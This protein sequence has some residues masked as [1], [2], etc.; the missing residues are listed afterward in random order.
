MREGDSF[1]SF[2]VKI[3][4]SSEVLYEWQK[5]HPE[6]LQAKRMAMDACEVWWECQGKQGLWDVA[7]GRGEGSVILNSSKWIFN[8]KARFGWRDKEPDVVN[9]VNVSSQQPASQESLDELQAIF[10]DLNRSKSK[11]KKEKT[12][13]GL[14]KAK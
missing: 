9:Q 14:L 4:V 13:K 7:G 6:F 12:T 5:V 10:Q 3:G 11:T 1:K 2:A 8:M